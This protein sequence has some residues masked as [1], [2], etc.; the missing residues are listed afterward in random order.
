MKLW[1]VLL[2]VLFEELK[3]S[4]IRNKPKGFGVVYSLVLPPV[5]S[6]LLLLWFGFDERI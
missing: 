2:K 1:L 5:G 4:L 6:H 3:P